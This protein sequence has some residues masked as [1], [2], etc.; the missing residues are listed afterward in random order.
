[1]NKKRT[2]KVL[3]PIFNEYVQQGFSPREVSHIMVLEVIELEFENMLSLENKY[4]ELGET[5]CN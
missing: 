4:N 5:L 2:S 1:M 3:M